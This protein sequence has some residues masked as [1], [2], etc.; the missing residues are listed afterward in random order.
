MS[1]DPTGVTDEQAAS[2]LSK[3]TTF[4]VILYTQHSSVKRCS[5]DKMTQKYQGYIK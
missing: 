2:C 4:S 5:D 3:D 1:H